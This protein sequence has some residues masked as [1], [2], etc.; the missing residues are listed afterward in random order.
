[1]DLNDMRMHVERKIGGA[2][3]RINCLKWHQDSLNVLLLETKSKCLS[4]VKG[5]LKSTNN[6][7]KKIVCV[8]SASQ[9]SIRYKKVFFKKWKSN[10]IE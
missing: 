8:N 3:K 6:N 2:A 7:M 9:E 1:M 5:D 10:P 4:P